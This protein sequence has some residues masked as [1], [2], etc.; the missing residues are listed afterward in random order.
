MGIQEVDEKGLV[1]W[2]E[3][4]ASIDH[5]YGYGQDELRRKAEDVLAGAVDGWFPKDDGG[6]VI[7]NGADIADAYMKRKGT[8]YDA[9]L[10]IAVKQGWVNSIPSGIYPVRGAHM[11][12]GSDLYAVVP[13]SHLKGAHSDEWILYE[14]SNYRVKRG[15]VVDTHLLRDLRKMLGA[16]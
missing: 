5:G 1:A 4:R 2:I 3:N 11:E 13:P 9:L 8:P 6:L 15:A 10:T 16:P 7:V 12:L 14:A